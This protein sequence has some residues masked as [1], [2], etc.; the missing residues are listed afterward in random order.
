VA[1][2]VLVAAADGLLGTHR[3]PTSN[4]GQDDDRWMVYFYGTYL[5]RTLFPYPRGLF[6]LALFT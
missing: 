4:S 2:K 1:R 6:D 3:H 5:V